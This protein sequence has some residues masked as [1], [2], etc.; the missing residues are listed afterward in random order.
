MPIVRKPVP[1]FRSEAEER[2][3]WATHDTAGYLD[4]SRAEVVGFPNLKLSTATIS[5]RLPAQLLAELK[6][7]AN[8]RDVP[9]QSFLKMH[10]AER[11]AAESAK[12]LPNKLIR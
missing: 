1:K 10:L 7:L 6:R 4:S 3:F 12:A 8:K 5:L 2:T 9:Y 11:V